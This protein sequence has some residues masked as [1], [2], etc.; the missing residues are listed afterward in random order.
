MQIYFYIL[1][2]LFYSNSALYLANL[3]FLHTVQKFYGIIASLNFNFI[4]L[5]IT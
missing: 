4:T 1:P 5:V 3:L 2:F